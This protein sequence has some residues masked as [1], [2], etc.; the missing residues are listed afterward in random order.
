HTWLQKQSFT[1]TYRA[2]YLFGKKFTWSNTSTST[3]IDQ[4]WVSEGLTHGLVEAEIIDMSMTTE[5]DHDIITTCLNL[6][7]FTT[8]SGTAIVR[9]KAVKRT[10]FLYE[11]A[12]E[13]RKSV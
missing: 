4:I 5:S 9:R 2:L 8:N 10:V 3:R 11:E 7:H 1:D 13:D 6:S 12:K